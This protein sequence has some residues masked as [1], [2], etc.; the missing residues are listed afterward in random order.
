MNEDGCVSKEK[1]TARI[2]GD[3]DNASQRLQELILLAAAIKLQVCGVSPEPAKC[4]EGADS[5]ESPQSF[6]ERIEAK[7]K[8]IRGAVGELEITLGT[9]KKEF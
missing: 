8:Q 3:L 2:E 7:V 1:K 4:L 5:N 9:I 6:M